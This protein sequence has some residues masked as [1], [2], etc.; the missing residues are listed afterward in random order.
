MAHVS[1]LS[2]AMARQALHCIVC[3]C[4]EENPCILEGNET[5]SWAS[6]GLCSNPNCIAQA[7]ADEAVAADDD[8]W[9]EWGGE[10]GEDEEA[11]LHRGR[12]LLFG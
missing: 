9:P 11:D 6:P 12:P 10:D 7:W 2:Q 5:C 8:P 3:N 4:T 1:R